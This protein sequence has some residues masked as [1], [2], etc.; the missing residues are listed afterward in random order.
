MKKLL[1]LAATLMSFNCFAYTS[2][3][4]NTDA[5]LETKPIFGYPTYSGRDGKRSAY[6]S[7]RMSAPNSSK[8]TVL[9]PAGTKFFVTSVYIDV[10]PQDWGRRCELAVAARNHD[11]SIEM[12]LDCYH[13]G[14]FA[15]RFTVDK[16]NRLVKNIAHVE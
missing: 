11:G 10:C 12:D 3:T 4:M 7:V 14:I 5:L 6:C 13:E 16:V 15:S 8:E 9:V 2:I 1:F